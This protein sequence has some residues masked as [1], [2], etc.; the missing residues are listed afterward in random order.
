MD[1]PLEQ[2]APN[3][4]IERVHAFAHFADWGAILGSADRLRVISGVINVDGGQHLQRL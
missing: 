4:P 3:D 1:N 2:P